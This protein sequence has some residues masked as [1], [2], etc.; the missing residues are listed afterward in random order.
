MLA[1]SQH[2]CFSSP[3]FIVFRKKNIFL[4][5]SLL[6]LV[7]SLMTFEYANIRQALCSHNENL[8]TSD[9]GRVVPNSFYCCKVWQT[10]WFFFCFR[11]FLSLNSFLSN[12]RN[13]DNF[14]QGMREMLIFSPFSQKYILEHYVLILLCNSHSVKKNSNLIHWSCWKG[15]K[16]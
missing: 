6:P 1:E 7:L 11:K 12:F 8:M 2:L 10:K 13:Q 4:R 5:I 14:C 3:S 15:E 9:K 16:S